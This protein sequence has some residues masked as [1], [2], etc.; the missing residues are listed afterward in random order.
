[1]ST[2][3]HPL[4]RLVGTFSLGALVALA[5][6]SASEPADDGAESPTSQPTGQESSCGGEDSSCGAKEGS[7][8]GEESACG[9]K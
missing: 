3:T 8:G 2:H 5:G 1:M 7:C 6:C 9:G 4:T